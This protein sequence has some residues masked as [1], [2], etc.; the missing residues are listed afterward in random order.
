MRSTTP[1]A[2]LLLIAATLGFTAL[3]PAALASG[4]T[5]QPKGP[6]ESE[7]IVVRVDAGGFR[8]GDAGVGA[9]AGFGV[10]LIAVGSLAL[11]ARRDRPIVQP[12]HDKEDQR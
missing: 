1:A 2:R 11:T 4:T 12:T 5:R 10:A 8:W 7:P 9:A 3:G 6:T